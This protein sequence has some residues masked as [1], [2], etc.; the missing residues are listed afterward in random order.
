MKEI[1]DFICER[2]WKEYNLYREFKKWLI[3]EELDIDY[4]LFEDEEDL[5]VLRLINKF[6]EYR[7]KE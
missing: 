6:L 7:I 2:I 1:R 5:S 4:V 3:K